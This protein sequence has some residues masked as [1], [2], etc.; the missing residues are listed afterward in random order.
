MVMLNN[1]SQRRERERREQ[2]ADGIAAASVEGGEKESG[3][4]NVHSN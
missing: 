2:R 4:L 3:I 1:D